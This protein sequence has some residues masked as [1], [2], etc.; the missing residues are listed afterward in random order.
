MNRCRLERQVSLVS[1]I[2]G[3]RCVE[4]CVVGLIGLERSS[5]DFF[6][7][8][9]FIVQVFLWT[10]LFT[11]GAAQIDGARTFELQVREMIYD[12]SRERLLLA[13]MSRD[14]EYGNHIVVFNPATETVE[15]AL[16]VGS[17]PWQLALSDDGMYLYVGFVGS[18]TIAQVNLNSMS[19]EKTFPLK[20]VDSGKP[21]YALDIEVQPGNPRVV[22]VA[23]GEGASP[24]SGQGVTIYDDGIQRPDKTS[25]PDRIDRIAFSDDPSV[26][27]GFE[28]D[29]V[30]D[31]KKM[32]VDDAGVRVTAEASELLDRPDTDIT[33]LKGRL[34][35]TGGKV[36]DAD[37]LEAIGSFSL[38]Y[39]VSWGDSGRRTFLPVAALDRTYYLEWTD[40]GVI[41]FT[42]FDNEEYTQVGQER[43][44]FE[45]G[46]KLHWKI[47][48]LER[49]GEDGLAFLYGG[50]TYGV[51]ERG[52][53][54]AQSQLFDEQIAGFSATPFAINFH[55]V[56]EPDSMDFVITNT[57]TLPLQVD[58]VVST[59]PDFSF[60][61]GA[62]TVA[63]RSRFRGDVVY[64][65][66]ENGRVS[67]DLLFFHNGAGSPTKFRMFGE[68]SLRRYSFAVD[69]L[70]LGNVEIGTGVIISFAV[71]GNS[72]SSQ[73]VTLTEFVSDH[74]AVTV[75]TEKISV[76]AEGVGSGNL[77]FAPTSPGPVEARIAVES[78]AMH[79]P[80]TLYAKGAA[81]TLGRGYVLPEYIAMGDVSA[82]LSRDT[83]ATLYSSG[84][85]TLVVEN[86]VE[87]VFGSGFEVSP[88]EFKLAPGDSAS[89]RIRMSA[90][91]PGTAQAQLDF[92]GNAAQPVLAY[93]AARVV[94]ST[95][96]E[97]E[98]P[99]TL[100][101]QPNYPN[102]F[103]TSTEI[104]IVLP[105][106]SGVS[107]RV[108]D[109]LGREVSVLLNEVLP[110]GEHTVE[111]SAGDLPSGLYYYRLE[112]NRAS[113]V[114]TMMVAR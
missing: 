70:A 49:W 82:G 20:E 19:V 88:N 11:Q 61:P 60:T 22:A 83:T 89:F 105:E 26:L 9:S 90:V 67:G 14:L 33:Y 107:L 106:A 79:S 39:T 51:I 43:F 50:D 18:P 29:G 59:Y 63:P 47:D 1:R 99:L 86:V 94:V 78:T 92:Q 41:N 85:D 110:A 76:R 30:S 73:T 7:S 108:F 5:M 36:I 38:P 65:P 56:S 112:A 24:S 12:E 46:I 103:S 57:G 62:F 31:L 111:F 71:F 72:G 97:Q 15:D 40:E 104:P 74:P 91:R 10:A 101:L 58:S 17:E 55:T 80:D 114:R 48:R 69:T 113:R 27:Y 100:S 64:A 87:S 68:G 35:T 3:R 4:W 32:S 96:N 44:I 84:T 23:M 34:Y 28:Y 25:W 45:E 109:A 21:L 42:A 2:L 98:G 13:M 53:A 8:R 93:V 75:I 54:I 77:L 37:R 81:V 16:F 66:T 95:S 6:S 52:L 102:P